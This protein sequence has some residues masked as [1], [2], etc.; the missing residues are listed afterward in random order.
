MAIRVDLDQLQKM[1][2]ELKALKDQ[3]ETLAAGIK[4]TV[5]SGTAGWE[6]ASQQEFWDRYTLIEP[7]LIKDLPDLIEAMSKDVA[8]RVARFGA[9]DGRR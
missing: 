8:D 2:D 3:T 5:E 7:T 6:G 1:A 9:A 4:K